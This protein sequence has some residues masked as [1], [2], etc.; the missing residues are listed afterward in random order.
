MGSG[1]LKAEVLTLAQQV[2]ELS[3][4]CF[5]IFSGPLADSMQLCVALPL[6]IISTGLTHSCLL[7]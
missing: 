4:F 6:G 2:Y 3:C 1:G 7:S 5:D